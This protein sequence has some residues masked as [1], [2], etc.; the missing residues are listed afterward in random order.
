MFYR[1]MA[2][3]SDTIALSDCEYEGLSELFRFMYS[4]EVNLRISY[5]MQVFGKCYLAEKFILPSLVSECLKYLREIVDESNALYILEH[6][7][8]YSEQNKDLVER[9]WEIIDEH[10]EQACIVGVRTL[11]ITLL[12]NSCIRRP[13]QKKLYN[14]LMKLIVVRSPLP[15]RNSYSVL[16]LSP[17]RQK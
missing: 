2:D 5:V 11:L 17:K 1:P 14:G 15:L 8:R 9:C 3:S 4:D 13:L 12:L 7:A 6:V 10:T 16:F